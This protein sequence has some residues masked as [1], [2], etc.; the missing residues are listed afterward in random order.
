MND[1]M[2]L[3]L[4]LPRLAED[5]FASCVCFTDEA[6]FRACGVRVVF[7]ERT[8]GV[9]EPP[10]DSLNLARN[11]SDR[12]S[13]VARN[14]EILLASLG[15]EGISLIQPRQVHG[16]DLLICRTEDDA[17]LLSAREDE[18]D[19]V[20]V[21]CLDTAALLCF[22]DCVPVIGVAPSGA[23]FVAHAGWRGVVGRIVEAAISKLCALDATR[24][25]DL[26]L[27]LGPYIHACHFEAGIEV[28]ERFEREFGAGCV[29]DGSRVDM[30]AALRESARCAGV[31]ANRIADVG[32]C[33]ACDAGKRFYS[34]RLSGGVCGRHAALAVRI[35]RP[36]RP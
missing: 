2:T 27:Y 4:P 17:R 12:A 7:A 34:Y 33:T 21:G 18:A 22:A 25:A 15:F 20:V 6:L 24:P 13:C 29:L 26:N 36:G 35:A 11:V 19:G 16:T 5:R 32:V 30:G 3:A 14:R 8:G 31:D 1:S 10:F 9:S 23:F 28:C